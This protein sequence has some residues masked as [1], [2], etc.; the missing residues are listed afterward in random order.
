MWSAL[1]KINLALNSLVQAVMQ[2]HLKKGNRRSY[3][4]FGLIFFSSQISKVFL[5]KI[6]FF[7]SS[8][9]FESF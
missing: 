1:E 3:F 9:L 4:F 5:G 8:E 2:L 7:F 6:F